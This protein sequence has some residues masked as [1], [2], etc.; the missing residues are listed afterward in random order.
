LKLLAPVSAVLSMLPAR[1]GFRH[2]QGQRGSAENGGN[3]P[4]HRVG[5]L[6][7]PPRLG[8]FRGIAIDL[9][10]DSFRA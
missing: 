4:P 5:D 7:F 9:A 10:K 6:T 8:L 3:R 1:T 2:P